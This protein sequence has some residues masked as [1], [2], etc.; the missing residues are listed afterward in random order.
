MV[1]V[2]ICLQHVHRQQEATDWEPELNGVKAMP[3]K[4]SQGAMREEGA[5]KQADIGNRQG[6]EVQGFTMSVQE[7]DVAIHNFIIEC[8]DSYFSYGHTHQKSPDPV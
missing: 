6:H 4:P 2:C 3:A 7:Q 1:H 5:F 8:G